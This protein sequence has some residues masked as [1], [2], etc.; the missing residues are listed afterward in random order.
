MKKKL[1]I[2]GYRLYLHSLALVSPQKAGEKGFQLFCTPRSKPVKPHHLEFL[3]TASWFVREVNGHTVQGYQWGHGPKKVLLLHGWQS[4]S[5]RWKKYV[6]KFPAEEYTLIAVDAPAHG[7]SKG[8]YFTVVLYNE[9]IQDLSTAFGHF[10]SI[11]GHSIGGF[12]LL[13]ALYKNPSLSTTQIVV[14]GAPGEVDDFF[15]PLQETLSLNKRTMKAIRQH[16]ENQIGKA[17]SYFSSLRFAKELSLKG[18]I[19]HDEEDQEAPFHYAQRLAQ[20]WS[21]AVLVKTKGAGHNLRDPK[22]IHLVTDFIQE[23]EIAKSDVS[24]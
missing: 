16:F 17:P 15:T 23:K 20:V 14:M 5:Y 4:H 1:L 8:K 7:L 10:H 11:V 9:L 21:S 22:V 18:L 24:L 2:T 19:V 6:E 13:Y 3:K 12:A